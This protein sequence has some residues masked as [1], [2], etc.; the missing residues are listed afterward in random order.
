MQTAPTVT[1]DDK[2]V[3]VTEAET[4]LLNITLPAD[5]I[6]DQDAG[7]QGLSAGHGWVT[8]LHPLTPGTHTI[9]IDEGKR[10]SPITT[11][12]IVEPGDNRGGPR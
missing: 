6:F 12:I 2:S 4:P 7:T 9:V 11:K 5:N 1:V 3:P 8:L 10:T